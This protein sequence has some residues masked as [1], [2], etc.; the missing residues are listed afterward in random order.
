MEGNTFSARAHAKQL[1]VALARHVG[2]VEVGLVAF[3]GYLPILEML[4]LK[5]A[6]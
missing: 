5:G 4:R 3:Q 6:P 1:W 2:A